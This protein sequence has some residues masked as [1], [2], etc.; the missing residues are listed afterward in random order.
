MYSILILIIVQFWID[1]FLW[2]FVNKYISKSYYGDNDRILHRSKYFYF[3]LLG[4]N[5]PICVAFMI[6]IAIG[7][8]FTFFQHKCN[9][10]NY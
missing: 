7:T 1:K 4:T 10:Q 2:S 8:M 3:I 6:S 5:I 9:V